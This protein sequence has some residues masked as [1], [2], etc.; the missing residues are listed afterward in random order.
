MRIF[1]DWNAFCVCVC[2]CFLDSLLGELKSL[3][4]I[5]SLGMKC[6]SVYILVCLCV[7]VIFHYLALIV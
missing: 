3:Q 5:F 4:K 1:V 2:V 6:R 7:Y